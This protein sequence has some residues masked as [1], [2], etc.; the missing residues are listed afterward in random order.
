ML[1]S[2][3]SKWIHMQPFSLSR[4]GSIIA[5]F[6]VRDA[7]LRYLSIDR[8]CRQRE[9]FKAA[10]R[11]AYAGFQPSRRNFEKRGN[12]V[13]Q[14]R[15]LESFPRKASEWG[16]CN[17]NSLKAGPV[18]RARVLHNGWCTKEDPAVFCIPA[19]WRTP[20]RKLTTIDSESDLEE[21]EYHEIFTLSIYQL[22]R[23][24]N[25]FHFVRD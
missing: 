15:V 17:Y 11:I 6:K 7:R 9:I 19:F 20:C 25:R 18:S 2:N 21:R 13:D 5:Y 4:A 8:Q 22:L 23:E 3:I 14:W 24:S 1:Q 10:T 16:A 12:R